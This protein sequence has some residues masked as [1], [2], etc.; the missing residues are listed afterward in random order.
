MSYPRDRLRVRS[1]ASFITH[2]R[3][4][5]FKVWERQTAGCLWAAIHRLSYGQA[6]V[7]SAE[8]IREMRSA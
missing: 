7:Q 1:T 5:D 4:N 3:R 6:Q 2:R 8:L